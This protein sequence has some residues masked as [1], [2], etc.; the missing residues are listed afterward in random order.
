MTAISSELSNRLKSF[1]EYLENKL[2]WIENSHGQVENA[3]N[4]ELGIN[5]LFIEKITALAEFANEYTLNKNIIFQEIDKF[6]NLVNGF[7][8]DSGKILNYNEKGQLF[9]TIEGN[10]KAKN[11][12]YTLSLGEIWLI[13]MFASIIFK[14][15]F[16]DVPVV[17]LID[18][19]E[20]SLH[21]RWQEKLI[22]SLI[23]ASKDVQYI[24][25]THSPEIIRGRID[26]CL[27][28]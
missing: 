15:I 2:S 24:I 28:L 4:L 17:I 27:E 6:L 25:A 19:P 1:V 10:G 20:L 12:L 7:L 8:S 16:S 11:L 26:H 22:D 5:L 13:T 3:T 21:V 9:Y 18:E 14:P 23:E